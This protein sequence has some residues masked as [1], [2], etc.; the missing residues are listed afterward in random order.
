M[1]E[2]EEK[3]EDVVELRLQRGRHFSSPCPPAV[4]LSECFPAHSLAT[5]A[6]QNCFSFQTLKSEYSDLACTANSLGANREAGGGAWEENMLSIAR[7]INQTDERDSF[8]KLAVLFGVCQ[9]SD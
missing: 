6:A 2:G 9:R 4:H 8:E 5:G 3:K 7:E 1:E